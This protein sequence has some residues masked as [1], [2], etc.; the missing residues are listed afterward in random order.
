MGL[1]A[2]GSIFSAADFKII[3]TLNNGQTYILKSALGIDMNAARESEDIYAIGQTDPIAIKRNSAKFSGSFELQV[4]EM[5]TLLDT[6]GMVEGTQI[7]NANLSIV[8]LGGTP[9]F[10]RVYSGLNIN[11]EGISIK[12][13]DKDSKI[14]LK[15][16]ALA[17]NGAT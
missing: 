16:N 1:D 5:N 15:W 13:K 8:S 6:A 12:A 17:V 14:S 2:T 4:G 3:F 11:D 7:E 10:V 9:P